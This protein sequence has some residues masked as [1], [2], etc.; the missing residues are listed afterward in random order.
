M[1]AIIE[2]DHLS[3]QYP[4]GPKALNDVSLSIDEG[5]IVA[6]LGP[7]GAGKTTLISIICG[8]VVPTSGTVRVVALQ[9]VD[10]AV[11]HAVSFSAMLDA[12]TV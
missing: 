5:E 2:V 7:N 12:L 6:M 1:S 4:R 11:R 8:L 9:D 10:I 3:K